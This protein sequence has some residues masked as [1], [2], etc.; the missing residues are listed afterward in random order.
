MSELLPCPFCGSPARTVLNMDDVETW[1]QCTKRKPSP[2]WMSSAIIPIAEWNKRP[3]QQP[4]AAPVSGDVALPELPTPDHALDMG[5]QPF[6]RPDQMHA[7]ARTYGQQCS[8]AA[9][10]RVINHVADNWPMKQYTLEEIET[11]LR[12]LKGI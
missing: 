9:L 12:A 4:A 7:Y 3:S 5:M 8:D 11:G 1:A 6:Y 2:C 10:E